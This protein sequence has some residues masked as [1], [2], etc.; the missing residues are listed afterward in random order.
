MILIKQ[1]DSPYGLT[2]IKRD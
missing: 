2:Y 1:I